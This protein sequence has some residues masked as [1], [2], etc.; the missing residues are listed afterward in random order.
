VRSWGSRFGWGLS[1]EWHVLNTWYCQRLLPVL[2]RYHI[3]LV[4]VFVQD[5]ALQG[6]PEI[7]ESGWDWVPGTCRFR[8]HQ[9]FQRAQDLRTTWT[10]EVLRRPHMQHD[11]LR[12]VVRYGSAT[13]YS[14][15]Y[16]FFRIIYMLP[17]SNQAT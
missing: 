14:I 17:N 12:W 7:L 11:T 16:K 15:I 6:M 13:K 5:H 10:L 4:L 8:L 2:L 1:G 3:V 9:A